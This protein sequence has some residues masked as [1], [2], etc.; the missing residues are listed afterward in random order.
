MAVPGK[1]PRVREHVAVRIIGKTPGPTAGD[2]EQTIAGGVVIVG[3]RNRRR[4]IVE[5]TR[6]VAVCIV[7]VGLGDGFC[8]QRVAAALRAMSLTSGSTA[9]S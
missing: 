4:R 5:I 9:S 2:A 7:S 3:Q 8:S 1:R 6:A